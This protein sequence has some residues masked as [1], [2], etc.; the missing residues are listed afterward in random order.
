MIRA[1]LDALVPSRAEAAAA[2]YGSLRLLRLDADALDYFDR[3]IEGFWHS[4][5]AAVLGLPAYALLYFVASGGEPNGRGLLAMVLV[6]LLAYVIAWTAYPLLVLGL[7][8]GLGRRDRFFTY[9]V[10]YNWLGLPVLVIQS[11]TAI[12]VEIGILPSAMGSTAMLVVFLCLLGLEAWLARTALAVAWPVAA[13]FVALDVLL[14]IF[15]EA[16]VG[17]G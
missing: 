3:S 17:A 12:V 8:P 7:V 16:F 11:A 15:I 10:A 2:I 6:Q 9:M 14:S 1:I 5:F 4:F 13:G